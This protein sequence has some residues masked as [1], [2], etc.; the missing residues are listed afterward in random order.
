MI[1]WQDI[2]NGGGPYRTWAVTWPGRYPLHLDD[3]GG[4]APLG[5]SDQTGRGVFEQ[6]LRRTVEHL[7]NATAVMTW[8]LFNE[9]WGQFDANRIAEEVRALDPTRPVDHASGWHDQGGGDLRSLHDYGKRIRLPR[10]RDHR[11]VV[12]AEYGGR[13][14]RVP[15]HVLDD[16]LAFGYGA[17]NSPEALTEWFTRL[18]QA[19]RALVDDGLSATVYTQLS[20]VEDELNGLLTYDREVCKPNAVEVRT[21]LS[22]LSATTGP[23]PR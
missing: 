17:A 1:V 23:R 18:H 4:R 20:D 8:V 2:P 7:R 9:G 14:L 10:R 5:R 16:E 11:P 22:K 13:R 6:E 21:I 19:L 12:L 15:G 3:G